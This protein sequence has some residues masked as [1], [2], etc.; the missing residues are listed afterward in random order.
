MERN[1]KGEKVIMV[2]NINYKYKIGQVIFFMYK[3]EVRKGI[4]SQRNINVISKSLETHLTSK[5]IN[6]LI[7]IFDKNYP[8][9]ISIE[10]EV[11][12]VSKSGGFESSPHILN[13]YEVFA[14]KKSILEF[15]R[16]N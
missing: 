2:I 1:N 11:D 9:D 16:D 13:E 5:I 3:N 12:L 7:I 15:L 8:N 14:D 10:Y 6:K 4:V